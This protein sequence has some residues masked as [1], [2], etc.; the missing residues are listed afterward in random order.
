MEEETKTAETSHEDA[1]SCEEESG[2]DLPNNSPAPTKRG[3]G[4]PKGSKK[5]QVCVTDVNL[6][7]L[8]TGIS[9]GD[10]TLLQRG[11]GRPKGATLKKESVAEIPQRG[12]G[13][14]KASSSEKLDYGEDSPGADHSPKKR[15]RPKGST[16]NKS[17]ASQ[18]E[19]EADFTNGDSESPRKTSGCPK[20]STNMKCNAETSGEEDE[21]SSPSPRKRGRPKGSQK[22][23]QEA[24]VSS[25][26]ESGADLS[27]GNVSSPKRGRPKKS[28]SNGMVTPSSRGR[29]RPKGAT[30]KKESVVETPQ[31]GRGRPKASSSKNLDC[32]EDS[33]VA[34]H[35]PKK[36]GRPKGSTKNKSAASQNE[37]EADLTNSDSESP[38]KTSGRPK[39]ST[40]M[41]RK[42]ETSGEED[43]S[44]SP[45]PRKRGRPKGSPN[46]K[47]ETEVSSEEGG[48][49]LRKANSERGQQ[50][51]QITDGSPTAKRGRGRPKGSL[52]KKPVHRKVGRPK[53]V[54]GSTARM[55][56]A[57][58]SPR[59]KRGR[60]RK[61]PLPSPEELKKPKVWKPLG[62]PRKYPRIESPDPTPTGPRR[63][64][65]RPRK[66][67]SKRG[68]HL[69]KSM[70]STSPSSPSSHSDESPRKR[71]RPKGSVK[72]E[73]GTP[74]KRGRPKGSVNKNRA[75]MSQ[76]QQD[77][78]LPVNSKARDDLFADED[79]QEGEQA[80]HD[81]EQAE[82]DVEQAGQDR[83]TMTSEGEEHTEQDVSFGVL[84]GC[85]LPESTAA[86]VAIN[87]RTVPQSQRRRGRPKGSVKKEGGTPLKRGRPK[88]S[89]NKNRAAMSQTQLDNTLSV[90][91]KTRDDLSAD[92]QEREQAE[93][94]AE[95]EG[96]QAEQD[97][98]QAGQEAEQEGEAM[99]SGVEE[100]TYWLAEKSTVPRMSDPSEF[101]PESADAAPSPASAAQPQVLEGDLLGLERKT[102]DEKP[103]GEKEVV[104]L[105]P[106]TL[107][108]PG[109]KD[110]V[111]TDDGVW[112]EKGGSEQEETTAT[113]G[114]SQELSEDQSKT[115]SDRK[116]QS[117]WRESMP[118]GEKWRD[119]EIE[120]ERERKGDGSLADDEEEEEEEEELSN[121]MPEKAA[122][123]FT[124]QV[125]IVHRSSKE[126][127]EEKGP[128]IEKE[129]EPEL[130]SA[131]Q[132]YP[133]WTDQE[134]EHYTRDNS[135]CEKVKL[136][137]ATAASAVLFPLL[138]WGGYALLPFDA[139]LLNSAPLRLV[140]S[141]RCSFFAI[142]PI[143]LGLL[144]QGVARL[145]YSELTPLY[146]GKVKSKEVAVHWHYVNDSLALFLFYFL[147][148]AVMATYIDQDLLKLVPLL[149]IIFVFGR[150]IYWLCLSLG[151]SVRGFGFGFS[152]FP[153]LAMLGVNLYYVS[154]SLGQSSVFDVEQ[155]TTAPSSRQGWWG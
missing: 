56:M 118:E 55:E 71:G 81:G 117:K 31:R 135:C 116:R 119:D 58:S 132:L 77:N 103:D 52:N 50:P 57:L 95:H 34:D 108:W 85:D 99:T 112:S 13:R 94:K 133:E 6:L 51:E 43:E 41:K 144:V 122:L 154:T 126:L 67:D 100:N 49:R 44:S 96:E 109:D 106:A 14:P 38:R 113:S 66:S 40:N 115:E 79:E 19:L 107:P 141:L 90:N 80:E 24:E 102:P 46:K 153:T 8:P 30:L 92:E 75:A 33:P 45:S 3:R 76:M 131:V 105:E 151:S 74:L 87:S 25:E 120:V 20:G 10:S 47:H 63:S 89:V 123:V 78:T 61:Y 4:R 121:W 39:R 155:P 69:R 11:R 12:R 152:F 5:L 125:K 68:A 60:P 37:L 137:L 111:D 32:G 16:K 18:D 54:T 17:A 48:R 129:V 42:A 138:V 83:E 124:P 9:N 97:G 27:D 73:G 23:Q 145:R 150:L 140:Y 130:S 70:S 7:E 15:G 2:V 36:R 110:K 146:E 1:G 136:A 142:I 88:G 26:E 84:E 53:R 35:S 72:K 82:Q 64:R 21:S 147:Q 134:Y 65:G 148:L 59:T 93:E 28:V 114:G 91:S 86:E 29:G 101:I 139:P 128:F 22:K 98:E 62:R 143:V 104:V 149:T 127:L